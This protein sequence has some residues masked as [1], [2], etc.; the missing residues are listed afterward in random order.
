[1]KY[2]VFTGKEKLVK[3]FLVNCDCRLIVSPMLENKEK[4]KVIKL[5]EDEHILCYLTN[6]HSNDGFVYKI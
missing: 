1:M 5:G 2:A 3:K 4:K 6:Q